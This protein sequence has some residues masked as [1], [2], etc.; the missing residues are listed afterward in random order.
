MGEKGK[1]ITTVCFYFVTSFIVLLFKTKLILI[2]FWLHNATASIPHRCTTYSHY[3]IVNY[4]WSYKKY[5]SLVT[6][7]PSHRSSMTVDPNLHTLTKNICKP[8]VTSQLATSKLLRLSAGSLISY[9][10]KFWPFLDQPYC[11]WNFRNSKMAQGANWNNYE[12]L[13]YKDLLF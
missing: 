13:A 7:M 5:E 12:V 9:F 3:D 10:I 11:V 1:Y 6:I 4:K 8:C 2:F